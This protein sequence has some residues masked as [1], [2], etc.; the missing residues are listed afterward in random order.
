MPKK[1]TDLGRPPAEVSALARA[2]MDQ[3]AAAA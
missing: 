3:N 2:T 1:P